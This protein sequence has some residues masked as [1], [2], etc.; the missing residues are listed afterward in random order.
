M[1]VLQNGANAL[2][3]TNNNEEAKIWRKLK[4]FGLMQTVSI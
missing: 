3:M 2:T 1:I 4:T